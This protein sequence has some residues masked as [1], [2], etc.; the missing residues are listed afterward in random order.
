MLNDRKDEYPVPKSFQVEPFF[1][2]NTVFKSIDQRE[3]IEQIVK[4]EPFYFDML[5]LIN[6]ELIEVPWNH[7]DKNVSLCIEQ[8]K[9]LK[10]LI[11][12]SYSIRKPN[13]SAI[14]Q[15][16]AL[17]ILCLFWT[18]ESSVKS[19]IVENMRINNLKYKPVNC[20][21]RIL[22]IMEKPTQYHSFVQLKQLFDELEKIFYKV[23][24]LKRMVNKEKG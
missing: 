5:D 22:F 6:E 13:K 1:S 14:I 19:L 17:F 20:E 24:A 21:E 15:S 18:N 8:W 4:K 12:A 10:P 23:Q 9:E 7:S 16:L 3:N 11:V 2:K